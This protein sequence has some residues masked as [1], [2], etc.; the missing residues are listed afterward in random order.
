[1]PLNMPP[2]LEDAVGQHDGPETELNER[3][4]DY[5]AAGGKRHR[6][7]EARGRYVCVLE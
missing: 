6:H 7:E 5:V 2:R 1:M 3:T 4:Q